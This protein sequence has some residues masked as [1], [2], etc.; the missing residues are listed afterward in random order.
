MLVPKYPCQASIFFGC[1]IAKDSKIVKLSIDRCYLYLIFTRY[2]QFSL[3]MTM[4]YSNSFIRMRAVHYSSASA[5]PRLRPPGLDEDLY[6]SWSLKNKYILTSQ[7]K[8]GIK[9]IYWPREIEPLKISVES[10]WE[11]FVIDNSVH[12]V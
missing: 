2:Y 12:A 3:H 6:I 8:Y 1:S 5:Y 9:L 4:L 10:E 11:D 7:K